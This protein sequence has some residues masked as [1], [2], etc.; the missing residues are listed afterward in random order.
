MLARYLGGRLPRL[1]HGPGDADVFDLLVRR[2]GDEVPRLLALRSCQEADELD[3]A[4][5]VELLGFDDKIEWHEPPDPIAADGQGP[6]TV[7]GVGH[8][9]GARPRQHIATGDRPDVDRRM[10]R[11]PARFGAGQEHV[12][13]IARARLTRLGR[14]GDSAVERRRGHA[15]HAQ[16]VAGRREIGEGWAEHH[17]RVD[18]EWRGDKLA[19]KRAHRRGDGLGVA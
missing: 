13:F 7:P 9:D 2:R 12:G 11:V 4:I 17:G 1:R 14:K 15:L 16:R 10:Q 18:R 19:G 3:E 6:L 5:L 8:Q